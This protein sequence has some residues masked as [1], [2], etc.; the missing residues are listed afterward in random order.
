[1]RVRIMIPT[2]GSATASRK[3]TATRTTARSP[4]RQTIVCLPLSPT[5][6]TRRISARPSPR[7]T[8]GAIGGGVVPPPARRLGAATFADCRRTS[9]GEGADEV[10]RVGHHERGRSGAAHAVERHGGAF[11]DYLVLMAEGAVDQQDRRGRQIQ[12]VVRAQPDRKTA[13]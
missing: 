3:R 1:M 12:G 13:G 7:R 8:V 9:S 11:T 5:V 2:T 10:L 6:S 4:L